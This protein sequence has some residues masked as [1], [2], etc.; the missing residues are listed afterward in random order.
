MKY[1]LA[2]ISS[3]NRQVQEPKRKCMGFEYALTFIK[4][5]SSLKAAKKWS[6]IPNCTQEYYFLRRKEAKRL[7]KVFAFSVSKFK[8]W[9]A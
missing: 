5:S 6:Y 1:I 9:K 3:T 4:S 8:T 2:V 7:I